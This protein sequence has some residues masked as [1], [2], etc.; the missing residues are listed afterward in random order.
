MTAGQAAGFDVGGARDLDGE[1]LRSAFQDFF[2][3]V[4]AAG[5][6]TVAFVYLG[7]Y[8]VQLDGDTYFVPVEAKVA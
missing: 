1:A 5:P 2:D 8:G 3:K 6:N 7:V 4:Q